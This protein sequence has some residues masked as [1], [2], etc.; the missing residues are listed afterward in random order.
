MADLAEES[1]GMLFSDIARLYW[2]RL[3]AAFAADGLDFTAGE[4]RVLI[5]LCDTP[6]LR[7]TQ[8]A[9]RLHIEP[10]TLTGFLDRLSDKDQIER[11]QDPCDRRAK[12][13]HP[14]EIG[15]D[16]VARVRAAAARIRARLAVGLPAED[17]AE[18]R[19]LTRH[20]R[21]NLAADVDGEARS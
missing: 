10:M 19:R 13:V 11:R 4:A 20:V 1:L 6:G 3:E 5:T 17:V 7:Q 15:R 18:L 14:T 2:R 16:N 8:L 12:L 9:E 21:A